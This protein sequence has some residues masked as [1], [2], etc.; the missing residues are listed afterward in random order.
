MCWPWDIL[1]ISVTTAARA[2]YSPGLH[3]GGWKLPVPFELAIV[4]VVTGIC[5]GIS[6]KLFSKQD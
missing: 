3:W 4:L 1:R 2:A 6:V 5:L